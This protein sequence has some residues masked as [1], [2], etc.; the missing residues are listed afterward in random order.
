MVENIIM[1]L[2]YIALIIGLFYLIEW[3]LG[4]LGIGLP[5]KVVQVGWVIV[6]LIVILLIWRALSPFIVGGGHLFPH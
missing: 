2:I 6:I 5:P 4:A 3:A 1:L